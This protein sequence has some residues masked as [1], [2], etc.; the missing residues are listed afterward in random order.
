MSDSPRNTLI[1]SLNCSSVACM[2]LLWPHKQGKPGKPLAVHGWESKM[3]TRQWLR[4]FMVLVKSWMEQCTKSPDENSMREDVRMTYKWWAH[5]QIVP[6]MSRHRYH[7]MPPHQWWCHWELRF[8]LQKNLACPLWQS[9][10]VHIYWNG[11]YSGCCLQITGNVD[12]TTLNRW[13]SLPWICASNKLLGWT[14]PSTS[15]TLIPDVSLLTYGTQPVC[16]LAWEPHSKIEVMSG[17]AKACPDDIS[18]CWNTL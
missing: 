2:L 13:W 18:W 10:C 11:F 8:A 12:G 17:S 7:P 5:C 6:P 9:A 1:I 14:S 16:L 3:G 4:W 15:N